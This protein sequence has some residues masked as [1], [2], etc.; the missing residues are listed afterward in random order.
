MDKYAK[1]SDLENKRVGSKKIINSK[2]EN[3]RGNNF[4]N[5]ILEEI[6]SKILNLESYSSAFTLQ[7][8]QL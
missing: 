7:M 6:K 5:K 8:E 1:P 2:E 4:K 3:N